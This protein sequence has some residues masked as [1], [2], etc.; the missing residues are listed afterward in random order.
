M[1]S[2]YLLGG[3]L[4]VVLGASAARAQTDH[5]TLSVMLPDSVTPRVQAV[6]LLSDPRFPDLLKSGFPLRL[7]FRLELWRARSSWFDQF[8]SDASWDAV[9]R[10]D[11]LADDFV[12]YR[13]TGEIKR[14]PSPELLETALERP[15]SVKLVP[16]SD[17]RYYYVCRLEITT[18][19][20]SDLDELTRWLKGE[21]G[22]AVS[23]EGSIGDALAR[24][25]QRALV[26][27][28]G[29]PR[30]TLEARSTVVERGNR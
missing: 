11:P 2:P 19:S 13:S 9:V 18:L 22:P 21:V 29:L 30:L 23:G 28:A 24:G 1:R 26:R 8:V 12:L 6:A 20:D 10:H 25:A 16:R 3:L 27:I 5:P 15:F 4:L 17:G 14:F 7:H